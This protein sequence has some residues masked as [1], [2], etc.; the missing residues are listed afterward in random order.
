MVGIHAEEPGKLDL[1]HLSKTMIAAR[2]FG[3]Q[4]PAESLPGGST[5]AEESQ[6]A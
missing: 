3:E 2:S 6:E 4:S 1:P 5:G